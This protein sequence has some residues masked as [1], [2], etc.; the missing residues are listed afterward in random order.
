MSNNTMNKNINQQTPVV[1]AE[2][3]SESIVSE[4]DFP[5]KS[6]R[7]DELIAQYRHATHT[8]EPVKEKN[9]LKNV[10]INPGVKVKPFG[11][12]RPEEQQMVLARIS[13]V[14][15]TVSGDILNF[16][17]AKESA[18]TKHAE[19]IISKYSAHDIGE[20]SEPMTDLM[21]TLKSNNP[22]AII[23]GISKKNPADDKE[24][25]VESVREFFAMRRAKERMYKA[26]AERGSIMKNLQEIRI[27]MEK[28]RISLQQDI[29]VYEQMQEATFA[30]VKE[31]GLDCTALALMI[32]DAETKLNRKLNA[33]IIDE[34]GNPAAP[35]EL[36]SEELYEAQ[37]L[38]NAIGRMQR[39]M[40]S[41]TSVRVSTVQTIPMQQAIIKGDEIICEKITEVIELIIPMW[42]WQYAIAIGSIKQQEAL[43]LQKTIRGVTSQL[44]KSNAKMLHDNMIA[45][46]DELNTAAVAIEDLQ[47]VQD[48]IEDMVTAVQDKAKEARTKMMEGMQ[49]MQKIEQRNYELM[50]NPMLE[51]VTANMKS[52]SANT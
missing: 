28:R 42:S 43:N 38:Q 36:D 31:F 2:V 50:A 9:L 14:D 48:Y 37:N 27:E 22:A 46:Q 35:P 30:Q 25:L 1:E 41:I 21:A 7:L 13:G 47:I 44:L 33:D 49:T 34:D 3:V 19:V 32:E 4:K 16:G 5:Q 24:G 39:R 20:I 15:Y 23:K 45:A 10:K 51:E 29:K 52:D 11:S 26:L 6:S 17:S 18:I 8:P 12:L 40:N